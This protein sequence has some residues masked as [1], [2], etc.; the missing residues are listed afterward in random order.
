MNAKI[1][2]KEKYILMPNLFEK[3]VKEVFDIADKDHNGF[4][5]K[6]ELNLCIQ[7]LIKSFSGYT[8]EQTIVSDEFSRLDKDKNGIIDCSE[9]KVFV[10]DIINMVYKGMQS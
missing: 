2:Q 7:Q 6:E 3:I 5:D 9:F 10:W 1:I 8:P 4:I